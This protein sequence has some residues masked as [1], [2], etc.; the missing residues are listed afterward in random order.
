MG[1][2]MPEQSQQQ[3]NRYRLYIDESG[4]HTYKLL[5]DPS[6]RYLALLGVWFRQVDHYVAFADD[7]ERFK[8]D[9]L[10]PDRTSP[11]FSTVPTSSIARGHLVCCV[12]R[13]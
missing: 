8:R 4:D 2:L 7:L 10:G 5:D 12:T 9:I 13:E 3:R 11:S 6:H 1:D